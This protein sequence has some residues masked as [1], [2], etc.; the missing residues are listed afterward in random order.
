MLL[1]LCY[2]A[3]Y[4]YV[5][6]VGRWYFVADPSSSP[7][8]VAVVGVL[9]SFRMQ[10]F[11][12]LSGF[13]AHLVFE[14]R[15]ARGFLVDRSRRLVIPFVVAVPLTA[16]ADVWVRRWSL[17]E[18]LMSADFPLQAGWRAAPVHL[19]FLEYLFLYCLAAWGLSRA[20]LEGRSAS[21]GLAAALQ[22]PE[23]LL[24]LGVP[25][26]LGLMR[27]G[28]VLPALSFVPDVHALAH[29]GV[30]FALG[31]LLWPAREAVDT[32][33]RRGWWMALAGF[34]LSLFIFTRPLQWQ[35]VGQF[36]AGMVPALVTLGCLG[37]A[38]R[39]PAAT[40]PA[41]RFLVE[42]S[43]WVYLVH[44]PLVL[45]LQVAL[46]KLGWP[47]GAKYALVVL[48]T[49]GVALASF[50]LFVY[51]SALGPWLGVKSAAVARNVTS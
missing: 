33:V 27:F 47:A 38:F 37:L 40:R 34:A 5:P 21:R 3:A 35:P 15:G 50:R 8:F 2:H 4:A 18:G 46:A 45:A 41:L 49:F 32:L 19:W 31:W 30:F 29:Y 24:L 1:G 22:F 13:F 16:V 6:D 25:L 43:Y 17:A 44:Y 26:G 12:A 9:H 36:L 28:E 20:G 51:R 42:S 14:R 48:V 7:V 10:L 39:V 23:V 11:F